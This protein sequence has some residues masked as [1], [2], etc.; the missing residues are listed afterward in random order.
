[1]PFNG[2]NGATSTSDLSNKNNSSSF[3]GNAQISTAQ[4][5]FGGSSLAFDGTG[6]KITIGDSY[7]NDAISTGDFTIEYWLRLNV[8]STS[9]RTI[10][11]YTGST[12]GW[13]M[14]YS[15]S[16]Y[17]DFFWRH[18]SSWYYLNNEGG[19]AKSAIPNDTWT[20][21]AVTR[22][23]DTWRLFLNGTAENTRTSLAHTIVTS[24][25]NQLTLG[26]R[27]D[28]STQFL[29]GYIDDLRITVGEARY[30]SNFTAPT[31]AHLTSAG[32]VNK[33]IVVNS[34][35]DGVDVGTGGINQAR[36][37]KAWVFIDG[38]AAA[39][40][41]IQGSYNVSSM[42]DNG[43]G[44]YQINFST[45]MSDTNYSVVGSFGD[46][47]SASNVTG[48]VRYYGALSTAHTKIAVNYTYDGGRA[49]YDY[50]RVYL[51]FFGN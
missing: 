33:H 9:Q 14:Y 24:S 51:H 43:T 11:N 29:N 25:Q 21:V 7:W 15:S 12:N 22:S 16:N 2:S 3:S 26:C 41:M 13:G 10:T 49:F 36:I 19:G 17:L 39:A 44:D 42:T 27:P 30:T 35:A 28:T 38:T 23:G 34:S 1:M 32:D 37:A 47:G 48:C 18:S 46:T 4:S 31:T 6:D 5:K 45:N 50:S 20:H 8:Q 40:S